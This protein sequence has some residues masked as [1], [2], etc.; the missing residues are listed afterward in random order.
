MNSLTRKN[1]EIPSINTMI[2]KMNT[3]MKGWL[4]ETKEVR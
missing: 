3:K 4:Q 2:L 1:Y